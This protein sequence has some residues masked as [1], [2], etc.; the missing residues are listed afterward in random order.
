MHYGVKGMKWKKRKK[1]MAKEYI[2]IH[3]RGVELHK[4]ADSMTRNAQNSKNNPDKFFKENDGKTTA[5]ERNER[6]M[7]YTDR[8]EKSKNKK[9]KKL[10]KKVKE[11]YKEASDWETKYNK[12][13]Y[14][15]K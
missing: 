8:F 13:S 10:A 5:T 9:V 2:N 15:I 1:Q 4:T 11:W 6:D 7:M 3:N 12:L 14:K